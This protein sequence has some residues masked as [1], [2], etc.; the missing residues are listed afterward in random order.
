LEPIAAAF[1]LVR[2]PRRPVDVRQVEYG[3]AKGFA[4]ALLHGQAHRTSMLKTVVTD[5]IERLKS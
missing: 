1:M 4:E 3:Q 5:A 2:T